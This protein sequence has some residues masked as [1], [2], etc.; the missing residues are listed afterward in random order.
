MRLRRGGAMLGSDE[1]PFPHGSRTLRYSIHRNPRTAWHVGSR[2]EG[3]EMDSAFP[4]SRLIARPVQVFREWLEASLS[5]RTT[6]L[7]LA[8]TLTIG[9]VVGIGSF[10]AS[11]K[12]VEGAIS[13]DLSY[14]ASLAARQLEATVN[15][16]YRD[17]SRMSANGLLVQTVSQP[18]GHDEFLAA[19]FRGYTGPTGVA[20]AVSLHDA[21]G[22]PIAGT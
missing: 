11:H 5:H 3:C 6:A 10:V 15:V 21:L 18:A 17:V 14:E 20:A 7:N 2:K 19:F 8:L 4:K 13:R 12:L 22:R 16:L 1:S 9:A